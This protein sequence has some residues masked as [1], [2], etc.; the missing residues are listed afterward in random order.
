MIKT[1]DG[2]SYLEQIKELILEYTAGLGRDLSF[3][4]LDKKL[5]DIF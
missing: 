5:A 2:K 4:N 3:Q 1:V